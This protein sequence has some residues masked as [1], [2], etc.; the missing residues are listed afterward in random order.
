MHG[1]R[2]SGVIQT[3]S[4]WLVDKLNASLP[5]QESEGK[6]YGHVGSLIFILSYQGA[7]DPERILL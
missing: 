5:S 7:H 3:C 6:L 2:E 4:L 1:K